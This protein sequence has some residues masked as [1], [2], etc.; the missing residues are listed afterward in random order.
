MQLVHY[1]HVPLGQLWTWRQLSAAAKPMGLWVSDDDCEANWPACK[2]RGWPL[3]RYVYDV[4]LA[5]DSAVLILRTKAE[6]DA[7]TAEWKSNLDLGPPDKAYNDWLA[8]LPPAFVSVLDLPTLEQLTTTI[9]WNKVA[10]RYP[11]LVITPY[12]WRLRDNLLWYMPWDCASGCI[13][14]PTAIASVRLRPDAAAQPD[15]DRPTPSR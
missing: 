10:T 2:P 1:S 14:D 9:A 6:I 13:W 8:S 7:F 11:G 15:L 5:T 12:H 4:E 3:G